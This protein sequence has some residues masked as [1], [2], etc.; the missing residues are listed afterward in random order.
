MPNI[1][2]ILPLRNL[3]SLCPAASPV[4]L[5]SQQCKGDV[6]GTTPECLLHQQPV[7]GFGNTISDNELS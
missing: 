3:P 5:Q 4:I 6:V 1:N 7:W 2:Y